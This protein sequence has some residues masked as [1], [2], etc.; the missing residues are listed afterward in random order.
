M[1]F[2]LS[3]ILGFFAMP[4][5]V[6]LAA[7][8]VGVVLL[9]TRFARLGVRFLVIGNLLFAV[10]GM[11][12]LGYALMLPLE[13]RF[14]RWDTSHGAPAGIIVLGGV[15]D[16]ELSAARGEIALHEA[17]ERVTAIAELARRFPTASIVFSGGSEN[18]NSSSPAEANFAAQIFGSFGISP[19]RILLENR[20]R[21]TAENARF[22]KILVNPKLNERWLLVTSAAHMPRAIGTFRKTGFPV[23]AY[24]VDWQTKG[25]QDLLS[26]FG[27]PLGGLFL[28]D[29]AAHEWV[30]LLAYWLTGRTS[31]LF[32]SP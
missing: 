24:P 20:S 10:I 13:E 2:D 15:I 4:S 19:E 18:P 7:G 31:A 21:N 23:E 3:K 11:S 25:G 30:G 17:A 28:C 1:F 22:T 26:L 6:I 16:P 8:L 27:S 14:P 32:P 5:N 9:L 29:A 12:P